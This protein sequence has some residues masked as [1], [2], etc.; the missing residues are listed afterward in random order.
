MPLDALHI[1]TDAPWC[2]VKRTHAGH[3]HTTPLA[4]PEARK[5][6]KWEA[7]HVVKDR[8]ATLTLTLTLTLGASLTQG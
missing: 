7:G 5:P 1:E 4:W 3:A 6:A 2:G 8:C